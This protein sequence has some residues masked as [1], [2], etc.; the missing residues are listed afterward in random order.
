MLIMKYFFVALLFMGLGM[1]MVAQSPRDTI[2]DAYKWDLSHIYASE[3]EWR[4]AKDEVVVKMEQMADFKGKLTKS[5]ATLL[6][7]LQ[8]SSQIR[9]EASRL[10]VYIGMQADIDTRNS[11][12]Q[13]LQKELRQL[14]ADYGTKTSYINPEILTADWKT[15]EKFIDKETGLKDYKMSLSELFRQQAHVLSA[16]EEELLALTEMADGVPSSAYNIFANAEMPAPTVTLS[17]GQSVLLDN[18]GYSQYRASLNRADRQL[19]FDA[20][21]G[22]WKKFEATMGEFLGGSVKED[23]VS[24]RARKYSSSLQS[25][26]AP[27]NIPEEVY[28][29][30]V[31]NVNKNLPAFHRYLRI[32]AKLLGVDTLR[33]SDMYAPVTGNVSMTYSY[34]KAQELV[35]ESMAPLGNEYTSVVKKAFNERWIDVYPSPG[36]RS[37]AY[38]NGGA[39]DVHPYILMNYNGQYNEVSTLTHELGH[40][41]HSYYSNKKQPYPL[42]GYTIF[43]AEVASTFNEVLLFEN[44]KSKVDDRDQQLALLMDW[45]DRFKGTLFRQTQFAEFELAI[46]EMGDRGEPLTGNVLTKVYGDILKKYYGH[47]QGVCVIDQNCD[48]EWAFIPHFYRSFYVYQYSTSFTASISLAADVLAKKP[49]AIERYMDFLASGGSKLPIDLLKDAGVD[50]TSQQPF[51]STIAAMNQVMDQIEALINGK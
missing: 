51:D 20:Y 43:N 1:S 29:S 21:W 46:H 11:H 38:S 25:A 42:A 36:K 27:N 8:L 7:C 12:F 49:G 26:L 47:D 33:Y 44:M 18:A 15:I 3:A 31:A 50:M 41:M 45:L 22:N 32:K 19:V 4:K 6:Q 9:K 30:L 37:G 16:K 10:Y 40:T 5:S 13:A 14:F 28:R 34:D 23:V 2:A 48:M 39:Y 35:L 24:A 17:N